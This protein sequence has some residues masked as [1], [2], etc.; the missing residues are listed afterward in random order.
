[1]EKI[2]KK[3]TKKEGKRKQ[4]ENNIIRTAKNIIVTFT[5]LALLILAIVIIETVV[6]LL[7]SIV[8]IKM[9]LVSLVATIVVLIIYINK[10]NKGGEK[11]EKISIIYID[12]NGDT[13]QLNNIEIINKSVVDTTRQLKKENGEVVH[14][15]A[16]LH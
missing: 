12:K 2:K 13:K 10:K 8:N 5:L 3:I 11:M 1:M 9:I 15:I 6:N 7:A 14:I 16:V 4:V